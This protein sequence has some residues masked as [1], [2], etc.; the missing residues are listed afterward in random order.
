MTIISAHC[1]HS[2]QSIGF[3]WHFVRFTSKE[4][5]KSHLTTCWLIL[6]D[7]HI[8]DP[9]LPWGRLI[10]IFDHRPINYTLFTKPS[11]C[12]ASLKKVGSCATLITEVI[13]TNQSLADFPEILPLLRA[14]IVLD[15]VNFSPS[16]GKTKPLDVEMNTELEHLL[17]V[18][19]ANR[20]ELF[21]EIVKARSDI[22]SMTS[23]QLLLKDL[24]MI[25]HVSVDDSK[26]IIA[27]PGLPILAEV[28]KNS[29]LLILVDRLSTNSSWGTLVLCFCVDFFGTIGFLEK[30]EFGFPAG[31]T[32]QF[33]CIDGY[34]NWCQWWCSTWYSYYRGWPSGNGETCEKITRNRNGGRAAI[35][36][37]TNWSQLRNMGTAQYK[38]IQ[39]TNFADVALNPNG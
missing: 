27:I 19:E 11:D 8:C 13:K 23:V 25:D 33:D 6:V 1:I 7:H 34:G 15:T 4:V 36:T 18:D 35:R 9:K 32:V 5:P 28:S 10:Q 22:S 17:N 29:I 24:K 14:T 26:Q 30:L 38:D 2:T 20:L 3:T 31:K 12:I 16:A 21:N 37:E 39:E